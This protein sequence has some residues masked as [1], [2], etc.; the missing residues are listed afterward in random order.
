M[1]TV[2]LAW[3]VLL[4]H[5]SIWHSW[6]VT[7]GKIRSGSVTGSLVFSVP[8]G[9]EHCAQTIEFNTTFLSLLTKGETVTLRESLPWWCVSVRAEDR[10]PA[11]WSPE[12][13][14]QSTR[15]SGLLLI[16]ETPRQLW[17]WTVFYWAWVT[18]AE[19][20]AEPALALSA[21][22]VSC[23]VNFCMMIN[24]TAEKAAEETSASR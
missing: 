13:Q 17:D 4:N 14:G 21:F 11:F 12:Q 19:M 3:S 22:A 15:A 23:K 20:S 18:L 1:L 8:D 10:I 16:S 24:V 5:R 9:L 2:V 6:P 7:P